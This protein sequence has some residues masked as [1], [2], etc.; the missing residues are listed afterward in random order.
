M[1][2][3]RHIPLITSDEGSVENGAG[4]ALGVRER[5]IGVEGAQLAVQ[6][7]NGKNACDLPIVEVKKLSV[8]INQD[9]LNQ[10]MQK[11]APIVDAAKKL[12]YNVEMINTKRGAS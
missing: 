8:F 1:A 5:Q 12:Q 3:A 7:L 10:S 11:I 6:V 2:A 4:F 9:A